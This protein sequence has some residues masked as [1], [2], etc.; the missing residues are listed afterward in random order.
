MDTSLL[1]K[2]ISK[3]IQ[4]IE[5]DKIGYQRDKKERFERSEYYKS[6]T[7]EKLIHMTEE[8]FYDFIAKL[9]AML[10]WGNKR[11]VVD[12]LIQEHSFDDV[13]DNIAELIWGG[14]P[15][16]ERWNNF[17]SNIKGMGPAMMS[18]ILCHVHPKDY[19][20]WNRRAYVGLE[21]LG[22]TSA[23]LINQ[24]VFILLN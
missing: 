10:I 18:E 13:K 21:F 3:Y 8:Q 16:R 22:I 11:Y 24:C 20:I 7:P 14:E 17:R 2:H 9:W 1:K 4:Q 12:K 23:V 15:I 6:W 19:M 5:S